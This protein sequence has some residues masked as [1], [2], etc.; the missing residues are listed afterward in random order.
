VLW[1]ATVDPLSI[2]DDFRRG[3]VDPEK[4]AY[5]KR[6]APGALKA[7][8]AGVLDVLSGKLTNEQRAAIPDN[9]LTKLDTMLGFD[10]MLQP[11]ASRAFQQRIESAIDQYKQEQ[12]AAQEESGGRL[13]LPIQ[14]SLTERLASRS[15]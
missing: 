1:E 2:L 3:T 5:V 11:T 6:N 4:V 7:A 14:Q 9:V 12:A 13:D 8:Q 10:G 15:A